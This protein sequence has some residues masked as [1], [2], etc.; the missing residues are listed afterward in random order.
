MSV[1]IEMLEY[2]YVLYKQ[3][4]IPFQCKISDQKFEQSN[5]VQLVHLFFPAFQVPIL[6]V[7][8]KVD[9]E[10]QREVPTVEGMVITQ[11]HLYL[12]LGL[13]ISPIHVFDWL[14]G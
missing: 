5:S 14:I 7:G 9:L 10:H 3:F 1:K 13:Q 6:L 4:Q 8:N 12:P 2:S 11:S